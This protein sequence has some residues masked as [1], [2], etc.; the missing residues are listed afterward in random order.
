MFLL[1]RHPTPQKT[2]RKNSYT[3]S[4]VIVKICETATTRNSKNLI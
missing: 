1:V 3:S 4:R 2:V